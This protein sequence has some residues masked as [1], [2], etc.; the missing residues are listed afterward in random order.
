MSAS[1]R[2]PLPSNAGLKQTPPASE[3]SSA[4][5]NFVP[6]PTT[7][8]SVRKYR[9]SYFAEP[10]TRIV[11]PGLI[12]DV[13][14]MDANRKFG[15]TSK[16]SDHVGDVMPAKI[17]TEHALITQAKLEALYLS[18]KREPL[19]VSYTR[20]HT[21]DAKATFGA[22]SGPPNSQNIAKDII[23]GTPFTE[24]P[25]SKALYK[26]S[27]GNSDPGEQKDRHYDNIPF[28]LHKA[29]FGQNRKRDEGGVH[30]I[31]NPEMD[32][33]VSKLVITT[34]NVEDMK[35][36]M[37]MLGKPRNLGFSHVDPDHIF[38]LKPPKMA[39]DAA[40][41]IHGGYSFEQQ[42]PDADLGKPVNRGWA[43]ATGEHRSF[44]VPSI[45]SDVAPPAKRS[46]ADAQNYGDDVHAHELL[47]PNQYSALGVDDA[48]FTTTRTK[49]FLCDLFA[50]IGYPLLADIADQV[51]RRAT[52][53]T[54]YTPV[55]AA[56]IQDFREALNDYL[57]A[58]ESGPAA[59]SQWKAEL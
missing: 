41:C 45:R 22:P 46:I 43:N 39:A 37:D 2:Q 31:L 42:Q 12:D 55:G 23:Y 48:E 25:E 26:R 17:P 57:D 13:K 36:T 38:G 49:A 44:G 47:Y 21:F 52:L 24:T 9:K 27:H 34:K 20:G 7:P 32:E 15:I 58:R 1:R 5:L 51:Y 16:N 59:L 8:E 53:R 33:H 35:N 6:R 29:R 56:S 19:G 54:T 11:H 30:A 50:K 10:G 3:S 14:Q 40:E 28:D 4:C 18:S